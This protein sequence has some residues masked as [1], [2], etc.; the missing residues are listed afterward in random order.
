MEVVE[1]VGKGR[2]VF[3]LVSITNPS[4][5]SKPSGPASEFAT[6]FTDLFQCVSTLLHRDLLQFLGSRVF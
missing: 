3:L 5:F 6:Y 1:V 4:C 2:G